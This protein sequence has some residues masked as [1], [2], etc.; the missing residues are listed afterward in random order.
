[1]VKTLTIRD[2]VYDKLISVKGNDESFSELFERLVENQEPSRLLKNLR[3]SIDLTGE[4]KK[5]IVADLAKKREET[6]S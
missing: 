1:M 5:R 4:E 6:R 3:G 2:E